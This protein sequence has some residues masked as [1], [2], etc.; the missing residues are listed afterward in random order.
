[1]SSDSDRYHS[2]SHEQQT[3]QGTTT[4]TATTTTTQRISNPLRRLEDWMSRLALYAV[5]GTDL[6]CQRTTHSRR[7]ARVTTKSLNFLHL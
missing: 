2:E 5:A 1:M 3:T 7:K 6:R 4:T